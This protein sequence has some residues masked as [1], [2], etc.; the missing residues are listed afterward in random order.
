MTVATE[1]AIDFETNPVFTLQVQAADRGGL[2]DTAILTVNLNDLIES[3]VDQ[4]IE[5]E[6]DIADLIASNDVDSKD[7]AKIFQ[8]I[9]QSD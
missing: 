4:I 3:I 5:L 1:A 7:D 2:T 6:N 9:R 8:A